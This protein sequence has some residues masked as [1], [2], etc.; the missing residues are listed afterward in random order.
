MFVFWVVAGVLSACAAG[1][2]L[3]RAAGAAS[4]G[5]PVDP[6]PLVYRRQLAEIDEL[7]ER[8]LIGEAER[9]GAHAEAGRRL[10][11]ATDKPDTAWDAEP[12]GRGP[13]LAAAILAPSLALALYIAVGTPGMGDQ[14]FASRLKAWQEAPPTSLTP[15]ELAA[16]LRHVVAERPGD[17]DGLRFLAIAEGASQNPAAAVRALRRALTLA[18]ERA[19][20]WEMLGEA[21]TFEAN[22]QVTADA[23]AAFLETLKRDPD[24]VSARFHLARRKLASGD[25]DGADADWQALLASLPADDP[26]R[27]AL[28]AAIEEARAPLSAAAVAELDAIRG[29][30]SG[31]A[32]R[33]EARPDD[34]EGWIRLVRSYA[35]L[36]EAAQRD[37]ALARA[38][39]YFSTQPDVMNRLAQAARVEPMR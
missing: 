25:R 6:T 8:G 33:L 12:S 31:L 13:V 28:R 22:G 7:A 11:A 20:L 15:P 38:R 5:E 39:E 36:G 17:V 34:P 30:V 10:L 19:D 24:S 9:R 18:P 26:R 21:L 27:E 14:P 37:A 23:E 29:M 32:E 16:V 2:I 4:R 35:V 3:F 1:L